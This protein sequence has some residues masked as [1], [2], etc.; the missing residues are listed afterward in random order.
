[1]SEEELRRV[2]SSNIEYLISMTGKQQREVAEDLEVAPTTFNT[3][4]VGKILPSLPKLQR[5]A[6]YFGVTV[7]DLISPLVGR[8]LKIH[9]EAT[10]EEAEILRAYRAADEGI[11]AAIAKLLDVK[12]EK[13]NAPGF[14]GASAV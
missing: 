13:E 14:T 12:R 8:T 2:F 5:I 1:M 10:P 11:R 6:E 4:C 3:W 7:E 9:L